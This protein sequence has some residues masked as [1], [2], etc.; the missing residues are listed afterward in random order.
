MCRHRR[1]LTLEQ[2]AAGSA[3]SLANARTAACRF[4][5][6]SAAGMPLPATS[7]MTIPMRSPAAIARAD[8]VET[9]AA[10]PV[11]RTP[12][13]RDP[14]PI[15]LRQRCRQ[16]RP[17][18]E[19]RLVLFALLFAIL[20][21]RGEAICDFALDDLAQR[22]IVPRLLHEALRAEP[23]RLHGGVDAAPPGHP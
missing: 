16:Q 12:R 15:E 20:P 1:R 5:I 9:V 19:A 21:T 13:R 3:A 22:R 11:C 14:K 6:S 18:N 8:H 23:H 7:A 2:I 10:D 17:L 4:D